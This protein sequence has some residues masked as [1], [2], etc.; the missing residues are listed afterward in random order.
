MQPQR[1]CGYV[2]R[3]RPGQDYT[4]ARHAESVEERL[5]GA[6]CLVKQ[7][8]P[9]DVDLWDSGEVGG[10]ACYMRRSAEEGQGDIAVYTSA[11]SSVRSQCTVAATKRPDN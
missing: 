3:L 4:C 2:R 5:E 10:Y 1:R 7:R 11:D 9:H 8:S 6:F